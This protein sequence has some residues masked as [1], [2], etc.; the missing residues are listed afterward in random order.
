MSEEEKNITAAEAQNFPM[1]S[2]AILGPSK[3]STES[4][5]HPRI[6]SSLGES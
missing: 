6:S 3:I 1:E 4:Y 5:G 2:E